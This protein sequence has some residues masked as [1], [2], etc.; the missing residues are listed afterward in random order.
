[1]SD[2]SSCDYCRGVLKPDVVFYGE[3][4]PRH[5]VTE[6]QRQLEAADAM[7]IVGSSLMVYSGIAL[8]W[9]P[10]NAVS[11][12]LRSTSAR[13]GPTT[14]WRSRL[15]SDVRRRFH[16][17]SDTAHPKRRRPAGF[18]VVGGCRAQSHAR[19]SPNTYDLHKVYYGIY[20][21]S[22]AEYSGKSGQPGSL[23]SVRFGP[24]NPKAILIGQSRLLPPRP[25]AAISA[26][27]RGW[28]ARSDH[29]KTNSPQGR[30]Q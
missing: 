6:A 11:R 16:F 23:T 22:L 2:G 18:R 29:P 9:Q 30:T 12:S 5:Q 24:G 13:H 7:L 19:P 17:C 28:F 3:N 20:L 26:R 10:R 1:M 4:V 27:V 25:D 15:K 8:L 14:C 21:S